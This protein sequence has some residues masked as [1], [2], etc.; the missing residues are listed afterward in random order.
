MKVTDI[1]NPKQV[2]ASYVIQSLLIVLCWV[3]IAVSG[4]VTR[5]QSRRSQK[6]RPS[7]SRKVLIRS[8]AAFHGA[9][10]FFSISL[11]VA[12]LFTNPFT[13]DPLNAF[14]LL[15]V[16][17]NGFLPQVFILM[18]L[19]YHDIRSWYSLFLTDASYLLNT[20]IFWAVIDYLRSLKP[21]NMSLKASA[22]QSLGD[23]DSCGGLTAIAICLQFQSYSPP[24]FLIKRYGSVAW[25]GIRLAPWIWIWCTTV[26]LVLTFIQFRSSSVIQRL[27]NR[28]RN[29]PRKTWLSSLIDWTK[30]IAC[31]TPAYGV[32]SFIFFIGVT[33]QAIMFF[34]FID[35]GLVDLTTWSFGQI[36]AIAVWVPPLVDYLHLQTSKSDTVPNSL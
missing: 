17:I 35:L 11:A 4:C 34:S 2:T 26:M 5:G 31:S 23:I 25:N 14:G 36:V 8:I 12:A 16:S 21:G 24:A 18:V 28:R 19:Q 29:K 15:P 6:P 10:C 1:H 9:Q 3:T 32:V 27:R 20:I 13:L 22:Y 33:Y 7:G 30:K